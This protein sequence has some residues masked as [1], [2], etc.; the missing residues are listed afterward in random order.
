MRR[1][2]AVVLTFCKYSLVLLLICIAFIPAL[3]EQKYALALSDSRKI[4]DL[5]EG[6]TISLTSRCTPRPPEPYTCID[7]NGNEITIAAQ[8][9]WD[10][11]GDDEDDDEFHCDDCAAFVPDPPDDEA[12]GQPALE[13]TVCEVCCAVTTETRGGRSNLDRCL[14]AACNIPNNNS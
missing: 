10:S 1:T 6:W 2:K 12:G 5:P 14:E 8:D 9:G 3:R 7:T 11:R 13:D 4:A